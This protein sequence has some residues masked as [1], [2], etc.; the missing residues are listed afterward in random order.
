[1]R[2]AKT[3]SSEGAMMERSPVQIAVVP[4]TPDYPETVYALCDDGSIWFLIFALSPTELD[5]RCR[6]PDIPQ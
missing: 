5:T 3:N 2:C 4:D 1:M 6:L